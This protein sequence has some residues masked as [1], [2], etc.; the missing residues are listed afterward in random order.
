MSSP[1]PSEKAVVITGL[2][3]FTP[4]GP[5]VASLWKAVTTGETYAQWRAL[6][7]DEDARVPVCPAP[8]PELQADEL[9]RLRRMDRSVQFAG[10]AAW[11]AWNDAGLNTVV[12]QPERVAVLAGT[13]RGPIGT[14]INSQAAYD[15]GER[16]RPS[17]A[18]NSTIG[19]LSGSLSTVFGARGP[20]LTIS[21][22]CISGAAALTL[23]A[24]QIQA[25]MADFAIAGGAEAPLQELA[26]AQLQ[27]SRVLAVHEDPRVACRPFDRERNGTVIGEGAGFL[28]LESLASARKRGAR[29]HA[30]FSGWALGSEGSERTGIGE[31]SECLRR[32]MRAALLMAQVS[33]EELDYINAHGTGTDLNDRMEARAIS[34]LARANRRLA[35]SSTKAVTGHCLGA[36]AAIE[37]II[38]V[39]ALEN[40]CLPPSTNCFEQA[41]DCPVDLIL[42][43]PRSSSVGA[44]L[45][46]SAAF[47]GKNASLVF[48]AAA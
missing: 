2:G 18:P 22:A 13:S 39:M 7:G 17:V 32:N 12:V 42:G 35:T 28:V 9:R 30:H 45:S 19:C 8:D 27:S 5:S 10:A 3:A 44:V 29:I 41:D 40:G 6:Q 20:C 25:G 24:Q 43:E 33:A 48:T 23:A 4:A 34:E 16:L 37:A 14:I 36:T 31:D 46:N 26:L 47:W 38:S 11:E 21:A 15:S 1:S